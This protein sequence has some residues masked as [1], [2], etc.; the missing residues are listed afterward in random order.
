MDN[1]N[2]QG[3][4]DFTTHPNFTIKEGKMFF[5]QNPRLCYKEIKY[6]LDTTQ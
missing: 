5:Q 3:I 6:L 2:L 4:W 1:E